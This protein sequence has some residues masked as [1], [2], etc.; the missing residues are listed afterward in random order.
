VLMAQEPF[1]ALFGRLL[2]S[3]PTQPVDQKAARF[4]MHHANLARNAGA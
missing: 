4:L 1:R 2:M 3:P